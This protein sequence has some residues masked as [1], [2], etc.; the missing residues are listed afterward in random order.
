M[1][2]VI[3]ERP[4][5]DRIARPWLIRRFIEKDAE[6]LYVPTERLFIAGCETGATPYDTPGAEP[7]A[8]DGE[9]LLLRP[10]DY[11]I[12]QPTRFGA[13]LPGTAPET[14]D[15][16]GVADDAAYRYQTGRTVDFLHG[17]RLVRAKTATCR[18]RSMCHA[19]P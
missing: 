6:F 5:I 2:W 12:D 11:I 9:A 4:K 3:R 16:M 17:P 10:G 7:F 15:R 1:K 14:G 8:H 19:D 18:A 13:S